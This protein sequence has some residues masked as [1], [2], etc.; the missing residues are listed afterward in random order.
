MKVC[1]GVFSEAPFSLMRAEFI[2]LFSSLGKKRDGG[3]RQVGAF[4][5]HVSVCSIR[6]FNKRHIRVGVA[7]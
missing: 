7:E 4:I 6:I 1:I 5:I 2:E 3:R